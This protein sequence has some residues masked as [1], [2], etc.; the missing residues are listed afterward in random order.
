VE[1]SRIG[2]RDAQIGEGSAI[3]ERALRRRQAGP[4]RI[5]PAIA[6]CNATAKRASETDWPQIVG[7]YMQLERVAPSA[8]VELN[9]AVAIG[10]TDRPEAALRLVDTLANSCQLDEYYLLHAT[11]ADFLRRAG[12]IAE[13]KEF[14]RAAFDRAP[15]DSECGFLERR[16][17]S[18]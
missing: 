6:A 17:R 3:L 9:R 11:R 8:I 5:Q 16:F 2:T 12:R 14:Y 18:D 13:A 4:Y 1:S 15:S 10:M 7:L